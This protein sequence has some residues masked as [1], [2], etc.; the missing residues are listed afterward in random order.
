ME[1]EYTIE[2]LVED[3]SETAEKV[4]ALLKEKN[5]T[6]VKKIATELPAPDIA[7]IYAE[8]PIELETLFFR[9]LPKELAAET[10]VEMDT[11]EQRRLIESFTD[12]QLSEILSELYIDDTVDI[13]EEMP[14]TIVKRILRYTTKEDR[15][16]I[17]TILHYPK[18]SADTVMTTEYVRF[19]AAMT[20]GEALAHIRRVAIDKETIYTCYVTDKNR[21]LCG[22][23]TA[24][25]LLL[26]DPETTISDI[27]D[28]AV[29]SVNTHDDKE[30]VALLLE[31]YGF[32]AMPVVDNENRL[33]GIITVDD[34]IEVIKEES[35]EDFAKMAAITPTDEPYL[36]TGVMSIFKARVPWLLL[37]MVSSTVSSAILAGFE[38]VLPA[39][40]VLFVPMIMGTGGNSGGQSS[41][42]VTRSIS[43]SEL[44][45]SDILRVLWKELRVGILCAV[46]LGVVTFAKVQLIDGMLLGNAAIDPTVSFVVAL[47]LS[48]TIIVAKIIGAALPLVAK[49]IGLDPAV[50]ASPLIT[51]LVDAI[52][53]I[54]YLVCASNIM[55]I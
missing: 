42:T 44:E 28:E 6:E 37:L 20:V 27:M 18:D 22:I 52:S 3:F 23:V 33:V 36:K 13:I 21:H 12:V 17:N 46:A 51:T 25:Q 9:L 29:I 48:F 26:S 16:M 15:A 32:L 34:A 30:E 14:A 7:E 40:L 35:E 53:L 4:T 49:K 50:M 47:S 8:I 31:R 11:D 55:N 39:V 2:E 54:I 38:A 43:L 1:K 5:Y 10:F 45:F 41:V 19:T 24:R